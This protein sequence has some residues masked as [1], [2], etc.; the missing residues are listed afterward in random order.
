MRNR[1]N[2]DD[3]GVVLLLTVVVVM[4]LAALAFAY[5]GMGMSSNREATHGVHDKQ[6]LYLAEAGL[7]EAITALRIG[8]SGRVGSR[9]MPARLGDGVFW[10]DATDQGSDRHQLD[11]VGLKGFGKAALR[12]VVQRTAA[13]DV[14]G[15]LVGAFGDRSVVM[16][17]NTFVDSYDS[18][19]GTYAEQ[20]VNTMRGQSYA[21]SASGASSNGS[22]AVGSSAFVFGFARPGPS[23]SVRMRSNAYV[24]GETVPADE[25]LTLPPVEV[26]TIP[27][28][29]PLN[30]NGGRVLISSGNRGYTRFEVD[31][32]TVVVQGPA[33]IVVDEFRIRSNSKFIVDPTNGPV[34]LYVRGKMILDSNTYVGSIDRD[35]SQLKISVAGTDTVE[36]RSNDTLVGSLYAPQTTVRIQSN[37]QIFGSVTAG[38]L[39]MESNTSVHVDMGLAGN[40]TGRPGEPKIEVLSWSIAPVPVDLR[41]DA[42]PF[43]LLGVDKRDLPTAEEAY[44]L[45][46][47]EALRAK[48]IGEE[49]LQ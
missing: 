4:A 20:Q 1:P 9:K 6:A 42:D 40:G 30:T 49:T 13:A 5:L 45:S 18:R 44:D 35:P 38:T 17:S 16:E 26:P 31:G 2:R 8:Y 21:G 19:R 29:G 25:P 39:Q 10:V 27:G 32:G 33:K 12:V 23:D 11:I 47:F 28:G 43:Q 48:S 14:A 15:G 24:G 34:E 7:A 41:G 36:L 46:T 3:R 22:I 37:S